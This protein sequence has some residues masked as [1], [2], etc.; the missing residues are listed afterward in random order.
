MRLP[1][2]SWE[3]LKIW[4]D[5][6]IHL[7]EEAI[8]RLHEKLAQLKRDLP[9]LISEAA[10]TADYGDRS[11]NAEYKEAK[12]ALRRANRQILILGDQIKRAV[13]IKT[14]KNTAG[15]VQLGST[16]VLEIEGAQ[17][18]FQILG[19]Q[20]TDPTR[21]KISCESPL[22]ALLMGRKANETIQLKS[23]NG[24]RTYRIVEIT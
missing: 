12:S 2:R 20:E 1:K 7:T 17:K 5:G 22:G 24:A 9:G 18:T 13:A 23:P 14:G 21:G 8:S 4:D 19:P 16:V 11:D 6:P 10:R 15:T 3:K